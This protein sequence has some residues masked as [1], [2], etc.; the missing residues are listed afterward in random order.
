MHAS[1]MELADSVILVNYWPNPF[2]FVAQLLEDY[3][4][5]NLRT[6]I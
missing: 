2:G 6:L 4:L 3:A 1:A 5:Y